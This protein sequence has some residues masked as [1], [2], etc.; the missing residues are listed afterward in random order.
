MR[1][2]AGLG[3]LVEKEEEKQ[4]PVRGVCISTGGQGGGETL[5]CRSSQPRNHRQTLFS[6]QTFFHQ[7]FFLHQAVFSAHSFSTIH[8]VADI[9]IFNVTSST[10]FLSL[11]SFCVLSWTCTF[12]QDAVVKARMTFFDA[13]QVWFAEYCSQCPVSS[14]QVKLGIDMN[15]TT[16]ASWADI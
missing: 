15:F 9:Y 4:E 8:K 16:L 1:W 7:A 6:H 12:A 13:I 11:Y 14:V 2:L 10:H 3:R 5:S